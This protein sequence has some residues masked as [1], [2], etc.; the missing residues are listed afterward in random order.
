MVPFKSIF[1]VQIKW[2]SNIILADNQKILKELSINL[3]SK[4]FLELRFSI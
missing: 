4:S 3:T 2:A 1:K